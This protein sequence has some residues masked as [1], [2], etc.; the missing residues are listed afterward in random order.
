ME[1]IESLS[2]DCLNRPNMSLLANF[3]FRLSDFEL[4]TLFERFE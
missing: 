2:L 1:K 3:V 4:L